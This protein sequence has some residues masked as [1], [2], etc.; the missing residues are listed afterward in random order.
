MVK[1][2]A[3]SSLTTA[4]AAVTQLAVAAAE[5]ITNPMVFIDMVQ[6]NPG[7][8]VAW[9]QTKYF[10]PRV[11]AQLNY[12]GQTT[13][14]EMSG[15]QAVDFHTLGGDFFPASTAA[16]QWLDAYA[17]GV[18]S[19]VDRAVAAGI[20]PYFF[21]DLLVFPTPVLAAWPNATNGRGE[22]EWNDATRQLTAA[23]V[24]ETFAE[25]PELKGWIVRTGETYTYDTPC[26]RACAC[27]RLWGAGHRRCRS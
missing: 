9:Q 8:P 19:F 12:T 14:G 1:H 21:V 6:N 10:D 27:V 22:I 25:F 15:T 7:D 13:T 4:L 16:R 24:R 18:H 20:Q 3:R 11:L 26:V 2:L 17:A 5:P 23:L